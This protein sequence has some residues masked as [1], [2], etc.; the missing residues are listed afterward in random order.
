ME[1]NAKLANPLAGL[2]RE[3]LLAR[4]D[5]FVAEHDLHDMSDLIRKGALVAGNPGHFEELPELSQD[6]KAALRME[7][8]NKWKQTKTLYALVICC[9]MAAVVQGQDQSLIN[10]ANIFFPD[11][12]GIGS[13]SR[14]D[15]LILGLVNASPYFAC[16]AFACWLTDPLNRYF[17]RKG[18]I[19]I[20]LVFAAVPCIWAGLSPSWQVLMASRIVLSI[21]I[22]PKSAT[23][24]VYAA[25]TAPPAIRGSLVMMWQMW[26][27]FGIMIGYVCSLIFYNVSSSSIEGLNWRLMLGSGCVPPIIV[28]IQVLF[29][30]ESPRWLLQTK[31]TRKAYESLIRLRNTEIEAA[32][33]LFYISQLLKAEESL[34]SGN[35]YKELFTVPRNRRATMAS[36]IVM[37]MQ[38]FCGINVIAY[39]SSRIFVNNGFSEFQALLASFGF[40]AINW[41]FAIPAIKTIDTFGRRTLLLF[42]FPSMAFWLAFTGGVFYLPE[43]KGKLA[44]IAL[45]IYFFAICYSPSEGPVPFTYSAECFPLYIRPIGMAWATAVCWGFK[46]ALTYRAPLHVYCFYRCGLEVNHTFFYS[47]VGFVVVLLFLPETAKLSLE[48]LDTV[49]SVPSRKQAQWGAKQ[50]KFWYQ[51]YILRKNVQPE[52]LYHIGKPTL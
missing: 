10:G 12:F 14:Y 24:P 21:G 9:S 15:T 11:Q 28:F 50:P 51:R 4:A 27:A 52:P 25:E 23:V 6:E 31:K 33:D 39:Y 5:E 45:G 7:H 36:F 16:V 1:E 35:R 17:G 47:I 3:K 48:E 41:L 46:C 22:G 34:H 32:R 8:T 49:F 26:T 37:F 18:T 19:L 2:G 43:G 20:T 40:G 30:P 44:A 42:G 29:L 38:Q 13:S